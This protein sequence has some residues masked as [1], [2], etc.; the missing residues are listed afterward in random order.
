M[1][2]TQTVSVSVIL[3]QTM[4]DN[5][6]EVELEVEQLETVSASVPQI[7]L[8][9]VQLQEVV[10]LQVEATENATETEIL[11]RNIDKE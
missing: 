4:S 6:V 10:Q 9:P 7:D 5:N 8:V 1:A 11:I 3:I 2:V